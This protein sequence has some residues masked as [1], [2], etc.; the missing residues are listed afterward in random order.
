MKMQDS[1]FDELFRSKLDNFETE[2]SNNVW[3]NINHELNAG[4]RKKIL[5]PILSI[6]ATVL[7]LIAAGVLFIPQKAS[8]VDKRLPQ[9]K[10]AQ[11]TPV[12]DGQ[13]AITK[14][15]IANK[16]TKGAEKTSNTSINTFSAAK[17]AKHNTVKN[18]G[19]LR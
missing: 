3:Q 4:R 6:A 1:E 17:S 19:G 10:I 2:P 13:P 9:T 16:S 14:T 18:E 7:V 12:F 8:V 11:T 5:T 15:A